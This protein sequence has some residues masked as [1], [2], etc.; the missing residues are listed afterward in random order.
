V[1]AGGI[2]AL[3][4]PTEVLEQMGRIRILPGMPIP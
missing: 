3:A 2:E 1:E 4:L